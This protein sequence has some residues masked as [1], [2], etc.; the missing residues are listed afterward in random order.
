MLMDDRASPECG[1][2][3]L[4]EGSLRT[5][6]VHSLMTATEVARVLNVSERTVWRMASRAAG[7]AG[8]F[9]KPVR[10]GR[11]VVRWRWEDMEKYLQ[12]LAGK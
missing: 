3:A 5:I 9:P 1:Q 4:A 10:I 6:A 7:G 8:P 12:E 2:V 11:Q